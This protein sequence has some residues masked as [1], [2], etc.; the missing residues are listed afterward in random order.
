MSLLNNATPNEFGGGGLYNEGTA[1]LNKVI[2]SGNTAT[3]GYGGGI[4]NSGPLSVTDSTISNNASQGGFNGGG[5]DNNSGDVYLLRDTL[6]GN[7]AIHGGGFYNNTTADIVD[8]TIADNTASGNGGGL[9]NYGTAT[10]YDDTIASNKA[11][12][13]GGIYSFLCVTCGCGCGVT[14]GPPLTIANTIVANNFAYT[15]PD[16]DGQVYSYGHNLV[17]RTDASSGWISTDLTGTNAHPLN[18]DLGPLASNGGPTQTL[19]PLTGSPAID[20]GNNSFIPTGITIDQRGLARISNKTVDIGSVEVQ[21]VVV[22]PDSI[23]AKPVAFSGNEGR[24]LTPTVATFVDPKLTAPLS[25]FAAT[26]NWG[27]SSS[28]KGTIISTGGG[29]YKVTG[30]H[31]Y[32]EENAKAYSVVVTITD[33][34][35]SHATVTASAKIADSPTDSPAGI[36]TLTAK[37]GVTFTNMIL[38]SFRDQDALNR[39]AGDYSGTITWGDGTTSSPGFTFVSATSNVGSFW[40]VIGS[41]K[42]A[43]AKTYTITISL[44]DTGNI[45]NYI[46]IKSTIKVI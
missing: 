42:Y 17:E 15:G 6:S 31:A 43:A 22:P 25:G 28:S 40:H 13:G 36:S 16:V 44:H 7:S 32:A 35:G 46:T 33:T 45:D 20:H 4:F 37:H 9:A 27:D 5:I 34:A 8:S 2:I 29:N 14:P 38:G 21:S 39:T 18:P 11:A 19:L 24:I 12:T 26:I 41:H 30:S 10:L 1:T 23:T 3:A